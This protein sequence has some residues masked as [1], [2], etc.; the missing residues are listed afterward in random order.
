V[1]PAP[2]TEAQLFE[3]AESLPLAA[4]L[5][6]LVP[7]NARLAVVLADPDRARSW[8]AA[9]AWSED[10]RA[11][12]GGALRDW[13]GL[14][15]LDGDALKAA[16]VDTSGAMALAQLDESAYV[17][18]VPV[19]DAAVLRKT[20]GRHKGRRLVVRDQHAAIVVGPVVRKL[21]SDA[22]AAVEAT[23]SGPSLAAAGRFRDTTTSLNV[24]KD[25][26]V[27]LTARDPVSSIAVGLNL[28]ESAVMA[29]VVLHLDDRNADWKA[30]LA[31]ELGTRDL[32]QKPVVS[33]AKIDAIR[34]VCDAA[35]NFSVNAA[36]LRPRP[37]DRALTI[38]MAR[39]AGILGALAYGGTSKKAKRKR[40]ELEKAEAALQ[41]LS[42]AKDTRVA[43]VAEELLTALGAAVG[44]ARVNGDNVVIY[45]GQFF[46]EPSAEVAARAAALWLASAD[47]DAE[48]GKVAEQRRRVDKL[49][50]QLSDI[51]AK[52]IFGGGA[53][54][55][56]T[57]TADFASGISDTD[58]YGGLIG[59]EIGE[60]KG[61]FG[62]KGTGAGG[63]GTGWGTIGTGRYGTI[64]H[65]SG[66]GGTGYGR[67]SG[68]IGIGRGGTR[69]S[70][71]A[72]LQSGGDEVLRTYLSGKMGRIQ[73]CYR[74]A[75]DKNAKLAGTLD[76]QLSAD[77]TG[78]IT[79]NATGVSDRALTTCVAVAAGG[80]NG[81]AAGRAGS[82]SISLDPGR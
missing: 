69:S 49:R 41:E 73:R 28:R 63:G 78:A 20:L 75:L 15:L 57:G 65:G 26:A 2:P 64:G 47:R 38:D 62:L 4:P 45:G 52:E 14:N 51:S 34:T 81:D 39:N 37:I 33:S 46:A 82:F 10:T 48:G 68:A 54:A 3:T 79:A 72:T 29:Q 27:Y 6:R 12:I 22:V 5:L 16:G 31:G 71:K 36:S 24:G 55:S 77:D 21:L 66:G 8:I 80:K 59:D 13:V 42:E 50:S 40:A 32:K 17:L 76:V 35:E 53:F 58:V 67:G 7:E 9:S 25:V 19:A 56:L 61:G 70:P 11:A 18:V 30:W 44:Y 60:M 74:K 1:E 43:G 23:G